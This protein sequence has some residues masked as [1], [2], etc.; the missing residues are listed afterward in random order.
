MDLLC[1]NV[2]AACA[3]EAPSQASSYAGP[4]TSAMTASKAMRAVRDH[5]TRSEGAAAAAAPGGGSM[6]QGPRDSV[7]S[8]DS[9]EASESGVV[10][11]PLVDKQRRPSGARAAL[12]ACRFPVNGAHLVWG[13]RVLIKA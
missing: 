4:L 10:N 9:S 8:G 2:P 1:C 11:S 12:C 5:A 3:S 13:G 6:L 7:A